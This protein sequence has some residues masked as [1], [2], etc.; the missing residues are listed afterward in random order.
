MNE[1]YAIQIARDWNMPASGA[2]YVTRFAVRSD[3][4]SRY[5]VQ[6]VGG[7]EHAELWIPAG[8]LPEFNAHIV[9]PVEVIAQFEKLADKFPTSL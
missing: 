5:A 2:G 4:L 3:F 1:A 8:E 7:R 6:V 9:G